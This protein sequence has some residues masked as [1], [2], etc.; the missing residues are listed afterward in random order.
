MART[1]REWSK[2]IDRGVYGFWFGS[3]VAFAWYG[4]LYVALWLAAAMLMYR[5]AFKVLDQQ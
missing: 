2:V 4:H 3:A 5:Q 1:H